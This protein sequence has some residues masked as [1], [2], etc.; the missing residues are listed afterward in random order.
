MDRLA[1]SAFQSQHSLV[2][3]LKT[4]VKSL[5]GLLGRFPVLRHFFRH[6]FVRRYLE[7][8]PGS[9]YLY[10]GMFR[11]HPFDSAH[12]IATS[13]NELPR[14]FLAQDS[15]VENAFAYLGSQPSVI[16][17]ALSMLPSV[18]HATFMDIG[19]GKGRPL[20]VATEFPFKGIVGVELSPRLAAI[21][22]R[23][24]ATM[25]TRYPDRTPV[26]IALADASTFAMPAGDLVI[27]MYHPFGEAAMQKLLARIETALAGEERRSICVIYYNPVLA[28]L[29]DASPFLHR[30]F[31]GMLPYSAE[32]IGYGLD[33]REDPI[34][35]W[36]GGSAPVISARATSTGSSTQ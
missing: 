3:P 9:Q 30:R 23:N 12:G 36:Q 18:Y 15:A 29:F 32:E 2:H 31:A 17:Q 34:T 14:D 24:A 16:R 5:L 6:A 25:R 11:T 33:L 26:R 22:R 35:I 7:K 27:F 4:H 13:G 10:G 20:F 1:K 19:C 28:R 8:I 21:A